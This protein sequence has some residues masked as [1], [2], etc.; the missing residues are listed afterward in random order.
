MA[1]EQRGFSVGFL[2]AAADLRTKQYYFV[3]VDGNGDVVLCGAGE[4][5]LGVLQND[6]NTSE[7]C[8]VMVFGITKVVVSGALNAGD[9]IASDASGK[10]KAAVAGKTD[11]SDA[12]AA[13]DPLLGSY[14]MGKLVLR[15]TTTNNELGT[16]LL[17]PV[18]A[19]PTTAS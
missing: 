9:P 17:Q 4:S 1:Q 3:K 13:A 16:L 19:V 18:G 2:K 12:G 10:A 15:D 8:D 11:T 7:A 14:V 6:P 5:A